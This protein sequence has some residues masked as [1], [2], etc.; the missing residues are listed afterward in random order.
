[1]TNVKRAGLLLYKIA[2]ESGDLYFRCMIPSDAKYGGLSPQIPKGR[3]EEGYNKRETAI[4]ETQEEAGLYIHNLEW[5][6]HFKDY[7]DMKLSIFYGTVTDPTD[8][9]EWDYET[10]WSGWMNYNKQWNKLRDTQRHI[11][12]DVYE[13]IINTKNEH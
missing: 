7:T 13:H 3:I 9:G 1:M 11:F 12:D 4:K 5:I 2:P 8:F 10:Y 6:K